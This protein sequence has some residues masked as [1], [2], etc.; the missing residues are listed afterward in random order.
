M[1]T[2]PLS[3][4][5]E[6]R[7]KTDLD[8]YDSPDCTTRATQAIAGRHLR[9]GRSPSPGKTAV[10]V[11]LCE[12]DYP[13][14]LSAADWEHLEIAPAPYGPQFLTR[15]DIRPQLPKIIQF[16][17]QA[18]E[19]PNTYLWGGTTGPNYD[20]SGLIQTA[21]ARQ[22]IWLPRDAYQQ[23]A[24]AEAIAPVSWELQPGDLIFFGPPEKATHVGLYL[25]DGRYIHSSGPEHGRDGIG[26]DR[27]W[28]TDNE[29]SRH[30]AGQLRGVGRVATGYPFDRFGRF[31]R[32]EVEF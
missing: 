27:L 19:I 23:E 29:V 3:D 9:S 4:I 25:G 18:Q 5:V 7:C 6:Y 17:R 22:G 8:L 24:F 15:R 31:R 20:C 14:W 26:I 28:Q 16:T 21:F 10:R 13:A 12:D 11:Q 2:D 1:N 32:L 30:Y